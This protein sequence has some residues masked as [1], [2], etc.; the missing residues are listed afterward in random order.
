MAENSD[1]PIGGLR[2]IDHVGF[3]VPDIEGRESMTLHA[4]AMPTVLRWR[5]T[6]P[7]LSVNVAVMSEGDPAASRTRTWHLPKNALQPG[8]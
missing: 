2:G 8:I 6:A 3:T 1:H 4:L 7:A 5:L